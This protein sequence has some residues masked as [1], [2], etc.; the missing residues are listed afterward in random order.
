MSGPLS[1]IDCVV[2]CGGKGTRARPYLGDTPKVLAPIKGRPFIEWHI[3][4]LRM[5]GAKRILLLAGH[6]HERVRDWLTEHPIPDVLLV[7]DK[8]QAGCGPALHDATG[9]L[10]S[11]HVLITNGDTLLCG[12]ISKLMQNMERWA[13]SVLTVGGKSS[14]VILG[15][16]STLAAGIFLAL[17]LE[18]FADFSFIDIGT[19]EG[20]EQAQHF[21]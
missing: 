12:D 10:L 9:L 5:H 21:V 19:K 15:I 2:L 1:D 13:P 8:E 3:D 7:M 14:G 17:P 6:G 4:Y 11:Y 20:Y 18:V 16:K